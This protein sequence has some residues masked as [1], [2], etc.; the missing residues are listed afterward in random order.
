MSFLD[1]LN[2]RKKLS[3]TCCDAGAWKLR[4][5]YYEDAL[6]EFDA[7]VH[8]DPTNFEAWMELGYTFSIMGYYGRAEATYLKIKELFKN[9]LGRNSDLVEDRLREVPRLIAAARARGEQLLEPYEEGVD[10][11][12]PRGQAAGKGRDYFFRIPDFQLIRVGEMTR[13]PLDERLKRFSNDDNEKE[14]AT[15]CME[16]SRA[17]IAELSR[18]IIDDNEN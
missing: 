7:A 18:T 2:P 8:Y 12:T 16:L 17:E 6:N 10:I 15:D 5:G 14:S 4:A 13:T 9:N 1:F 11:S 3:K